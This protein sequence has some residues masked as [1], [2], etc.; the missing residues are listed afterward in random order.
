M[1]MNT[2]NF[3]I[4][5]KTVCN[6]V[7]K[8]HGDFLIYLIITHVNVKLWIIKPNNKK[9]IWNR[10]FKTGKIVVILYYAIWPDG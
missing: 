6:I 8:K 5:R 4:S 3:I 7:K 9:K 10:I 2:K 1:N